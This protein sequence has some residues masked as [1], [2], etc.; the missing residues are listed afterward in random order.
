MLP[1]PSTCVSRTLLG[2]ARWSARDAITCSAAIR[3][4]CR[5]C[6]R[7]VRYIGRGSHPSQ[8]MM[9]RTAGGSPGLMCTSSTYK[10]DGRKMFSS[11]VSATCSGNVSATF[12]QF[13][14]V[15]RWNT[16]GTT[17]SN[18]A[19]TSP[20]GQRHTIFWP[21]WPLRHAGEGGTRTPV[22][23]FSFKAARACGSCT[24]GVLS[25]SGR[26]SRTTFK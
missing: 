19:R 10:E 21:Y 14:S 24:D 2:P 5:C 12:R 16:A 17:C 8:R 7:E 18:V 3:C 11:A 26:T 23:T 25:H 22:S 13:F 6:S 1:Q 15:T 4:R 20:G 9:R